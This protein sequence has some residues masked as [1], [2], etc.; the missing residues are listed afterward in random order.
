MLETVFVPPYAIQLKVNLHKRRCGLKKRNTRGIIHLSLMSV[1]RKRERFKVS[2]SC[3]SCTAL[4][5]CG[6]SHANH[7]PTRKSPF[8]VTLESKTWPKIQISKSVDA[9]IWIIKITVFVCFGS[10]PPPFF[11]CF[12][13]K[14]GDSKRVQEIV[15]RS[16]N[17]IVFS[18]FRLSINFPFQIRNYSFHRYTRRS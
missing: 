18:H 16:C 14:H 5:L 1:S 6:Y 12:A 11:F 17:R 8:K 3:N 2:F 4:S 7:I 15:V 10:S 9:I 13:A